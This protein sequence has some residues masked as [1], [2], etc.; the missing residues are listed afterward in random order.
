[1]RVSGPEGLRAREAPAGS[2]L[3]RGSLGLRG[4]GRPGRHGPGLE[5]PAIPRSG[6]REPSGLEAQVQV[7]VRLQLES[8]SESGSGSQAPEPRS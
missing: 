8:E 5:I 7:Q 3:L 2:P 6:A 4:S 1:L